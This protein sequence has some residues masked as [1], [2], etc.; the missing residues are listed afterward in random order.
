MDWQHIVA[1]LWPQVQ[2]KHLWPE[3]P[4]PRV[5]KLDT[6]LAMHMR[7]KQMTLNAATCDALAE[8]LPAATVVEALLDHGTSHYT[9]CPW[10]LSTHL[11]LYATAK[12]ELQ[13][14]SLAK[15]ATDTF[16]DV[17]ANTSCVKELQTPLPDL[18]RHL[19]GGALDGALA[20]LYTHIWGVDLEGS[21][22]PALIRRLA[23]IPYLDRRQWTQSLQRFARLLRPLFEAEGQQGQAQMPAL[24]HHSLE[25]YAPDELLQGLRTFAERVQDIQEFRDTIQDFSD[26]L[27]LLGYGA[28]EVG[29]G[30]GQRPSIDADALYYMQLAQGYR[31][32]LRR[33][34]MA[35]SSAMDPYSHALWEASKPLQDIDIWTSFGKLLPG[36]SQVWVRRQG[37]FFEPC[38]SIPDCLIVLDSSGSMA[39][40]RE[41][42]SHAVL[43]AGCATEAYLR[44]E[45]RVAVYNFSDA[46]ADGKTVQ[47][48]TTDRYAIYRGL[49]VYHGGGTS[50][51]LRDLDDLRQAAAHAT[52]DLLLITD[53]YITNLEEVIDYLVEMEG[54]ITV[55][56]IGEK[57]AT[58]R[59]RRVM[60]NPPRLHIFS[61]LESHDIPHIVLGQVRQYFGPSNV[62]T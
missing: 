3:L 62:F 25:Q 47:P 48:F 22:D 50:V 43:G 8:H 58:E 27:V 5:G 32:P 19:G 44:R 28:E 53:M 13:R 59:W 46:H 10:D 18:Y 33:V 56:H 54:R 49:C 35:R 6:L 12:A 9:R 20:A 1:D 7:S 42:L 51:R 29:A 57:D 26:E 4:M 31:L 36:L 24:G 17:V 61:V 37:L 34:P 55:I 15:L 38:D 30:L 23:R 52:P 2:R 14:K 39:N 41:R 45:A 60:G 16:I 40:P 11:Q 21:A